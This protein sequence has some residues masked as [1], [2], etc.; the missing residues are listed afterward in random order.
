MSSEQIGLMAVTLVPTKPD[1]EIVADLKARLTV[2][3]APVLAILDEATAAG[4]V[5]QWDNLSPAPPLFKYQIHG[6]KVVKHF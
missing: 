3:M 2:A 1:A 5:F 6:L 4:L